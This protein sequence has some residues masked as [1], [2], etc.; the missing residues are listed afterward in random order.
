MEGVELFETAAFARC[1]GLSRNQA[2]IGGHQKVGMK[3]DLAEPSETVDRR[4]H[5]RAVGD[6]DKEE[7]A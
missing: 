6:R 1:G 5:T 4:I 7:L 2:Q 3:T